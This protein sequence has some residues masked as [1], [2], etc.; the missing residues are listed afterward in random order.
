M[1]GYAKSLMPLATEVMPF[2]DQKGYGLDGR[3]VESDLWRAHARRLHGA[4]DDERWIRDDLSVWFTWLGLWAHWGFNVVNVGPDTA[5]GLLLTDPESLKFDDF[6]LPLPAVLVVAP[7]GFLSSTT[8]HLMERFRLKNRDGRLDGG[9]TRAES[10]PASSELVRVVEWATMAS[11]GALN[12]DSISE[13][14]ARDGG[15]AAWTAEDVEPYWR[16]PDNETAWA[17]IYQTS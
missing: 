12:R 9:L 14:L 13:D 3:L 11:N 17:H 8:L 4:Y 1:A 5:A 16:G 6:R 10:M 7:S 15:F 2:V